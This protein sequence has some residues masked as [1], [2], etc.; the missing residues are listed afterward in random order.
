MEDVK[1]S[2]GAYWVFV[3]FLINLGLNAVNEIMNEKRK[4]E[5]KNNEKMSKKYEEKVVLMH[6]CTSSGDK[7]K[8]ECTEWRKS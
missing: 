4:H 1:K 7:Y 3:F 8:P 5:W 6:M 2:V